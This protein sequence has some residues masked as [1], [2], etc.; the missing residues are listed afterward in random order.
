MFT[1]YIYTMGSVIN[2]PAMIPVVY[3][4]FS[5]EGRSLMIFSRL[6]SVDVHTRMVAINIFNVLDCDI[7]IQN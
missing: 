7:I 5:R 1:Y 2:M 3:K 4:L 6:A